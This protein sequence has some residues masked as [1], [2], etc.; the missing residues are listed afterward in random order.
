MAFDRQ[1]IPNSPGELVFY[2]EQLDCWLEVDKTD[3]TPTVNG[4][5]Q[6]TLNP[7]NSRT[8]SGL[9]EPEPDLIV[10]N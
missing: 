2:D 8:I 5:F 6:I 9:N 7:K 3:F 1:I 10:E 4:D